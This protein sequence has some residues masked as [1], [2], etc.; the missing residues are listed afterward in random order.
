MQ[1]NI[2]KLEKENLF[3]NNSDDQ[4]TDLEVVYSQP[5]KMKITIKNYNNNIA[6]FFR[7]LLSFLEQATSSQFLT[8]RMQHLL[9]SLYTR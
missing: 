7:K 6:L 9:D 1:A 3:L 5:L 2:T 4:Q 8:H